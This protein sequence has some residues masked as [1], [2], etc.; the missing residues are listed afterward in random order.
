MWF[1]YRWMFVSIFTIIFF[2]L[3]YVFDISP[4]LTMLDELH[5]NKEEL[6][7]AVLNKNHVNTNTYTKTTDQVLQ[8]LLIYI[9][10]SGLEIKSFRHLP[11]QLQIIL[12][13][14]YQRILAM[15]NMIEENAG[16][17]TIKNMD[18]KW[19]EGNI[20]QMNMNIQIN[21]GFK[22][23]P[24]NINKIYSPLFCT[25]DLID[26]WFL[27]QEEDL[28][29]SPLDQIRLA[30]FFRQGYK[31]KALMMFSD[32]SI[33][34]VVKGDVIGKEKAQI[35]GIF[36]DYVLLQLQNGK[37]VKMEMEND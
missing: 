37:Q 5:K 25:P 10:R 9:H 6:K 16:A 17:V 35:M 15:I 31:H 23:F 4:M 13:G 8:P 34:E 33:K 19:D 24:M 21:H 29:S 7:Q 11:S 12:R 28:L 30:G 22:V 18:I 32:H 1:R 36:P 2:T 26:E 14:E 3:L 27:H 20:F